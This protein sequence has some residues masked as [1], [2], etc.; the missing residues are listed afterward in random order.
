M[1]RRYLLAT[2]CIWDSTI[3]THFPPRLLILYHQECQGIIIPL[4]CSFYASR[5]ASIRC[6]PIHSSKFNICWNSSLLNRCKNSAVDNWYLASNS[7]RRFS[8]YRM[9]S[10]EVCS[11]DFRPHYK[12]QKNRSSAMPLPGPSRPGVLNY[13]D[14]W[15]SAE[16]LPCSRMNDYNQ[17][18]LYFNYSPIG[19]R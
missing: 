8:V 1:R 19:V 12:P 3:F 11:E 15:I 7:W 2:V 6:S 16:V 9:P 18:Y 4:I 10:T 5:L 14:T 13:L 17:R